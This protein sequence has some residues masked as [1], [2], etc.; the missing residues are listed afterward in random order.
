MRK[1]ILIIA[2]TS[3]I[4]AGAFARMQFLGWLALM[5]LGSILIFSAIHLLVHIPQIRHSQR[6]KKADLMWIGLSHLSFLGI[7]LF[8]FDFDDSSGV[9]ILEGLIGIRGMIGS[10]LAIWLISAAV[11]LYLVAVVVL[12]V[13]LKK[14]HQAISSKALGFALLG[15]FLILVAPPAGFFLYTEFQRASAVRA[16]EEQGEFNSLERALRNPE[17]VKY[18]RL[19]R[20]PDSYT[21]IP[22]GVFELHSLETLEMGS[23]AI[24]S[25]PPA[26]SK[27]QQLK[28]LQLYYNKI[29][30]LPAE[31]GSLQS[32]EVLDLGNNELDSIHARICDCLKLRELSLG[33][34]IGRL[35]DCLRR[36][37]NLESLV[38]QSSRSGELME[39]LKGFGNLKTL[40][41]YNYGE[42]VWDGAGYDSLKQDLPNTKVGF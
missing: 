21:E 30:V 32:L 22:P 6:K 4:V 2:M 7:F 26:I 8:Q 11:T 25:I 15:V 10:A 38:V 19:Y 9:V 28:D 5:G 34:H 35:P 18:L 12:F 1:A 39:Q 29:S 37:P 3:A 17:Q 42:G 23:N 13:R 24:S 41:V 14:I 40:R 16:D 31:I 20:Y 33:G 36:H 27:L